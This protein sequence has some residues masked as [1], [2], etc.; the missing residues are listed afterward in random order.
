MR[1]TRL[2]GLQA[3]PFYF[4]KSFIQFLRPRQVVFP[5]RNPAS[6]H[7]FTRLAVVFFVA[8]FLCR[9]ALANV[10]A[11]N[12]KEKRP[13]RKAAAYNGESKP[14]ALA[15][16]RIQPRSKF[17]SPRSQLAALHRQGVLHRFHPCDNFWDVSLVSGDTASGSPAGHPASEGFLNGVIGAANGPRPRRVRAARMPGEEMLEAQ[18][19]ENW[20]SVT[21]RRRV[22]FPW[23][24]ITSGCGPCCHFNVSMSKAHKSHLARQCRRIPH[25]AAARRGRDFRRAVILLAEVPLTIGISV[26]ITACNCKS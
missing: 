4:Q 26:G 9:L 8:G 21:P 10:L 17:S 11:R 6:R 2:S 20:P 13:L 19:A 5:C 14:L 23:H 16:N 25:R 24:R 15:Q 12:K 18:A 1:Q 22:V 7:S 3:I